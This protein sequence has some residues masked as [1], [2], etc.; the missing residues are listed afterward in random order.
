MN[1]LSLLNNPTNN[2][3]G[4]ATPSGSYLSETLRALQ[5]ERRDY[6]ED[7]RSWSS[8]LRRP[9]SDVELRQI[10][11]DALA[12]VYDAQGALLPIGVGHGK[13]LI[14]FLAGAILPDVRYTLF[15]TPAP[16]V[17]ARARDWDEWSA[18]FALPTCRI[19]SYWELSHRPA[20]LQGILAGIGPRHLLVVADEAH[21]LGDPKA[22]RTKRI[23]RTARDFPAIRWLFMSGTLT[24]KSLRQFAHLSAIALRDKSPLPRPAKDP[25][26]RSIDL[27]AWSECVDDGGKPDGTSWSKIRHLLEQYDLAA[28][29]TRGQ[30][31]TQRARKAF[32]L[33]LGGSIGVVAS[34]KSALGC[35]LLIEQVAAPLS[36]EVTEALGMVLAGE[37]PDGE[38]LVDDVSSWRAGRQV[39][40]GFY[41]RWDWRAINR[42]TPDQ[43]WLRARQRWFQHVRRELDIASAPDYDSPALVEAETRRRIDAWEERRRPLIQHALISWDQERHKP[44]PPTVPV[45]IDR[46]ILAWVVEGLGERRPLIWYE[47]TAVAD[48]L[49][50]L[51]LE[52]IRAGQEVV[53]ERRP[54]CVSIP[55]HREGLNLQAWDDNIILECPS[56]GKA[57]E[58]L[59]GRTHRPGQLSDEVKASVLIQGALGASLEKARRSARYIE[60][61][62]GQTQKLN[63][64]TY[65][66]A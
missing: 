51:G 36:D 47:S 29:S 43:Q 64:A 38:V 35:S 26:H 65:T 2:P 14:G 11:A 17:Q 10:Q 8:F 32:Q 25:K 45:W 50:R 59:L 12:A 57:G 3:G 48:E 21:R 58:Q 44:V 18:H 19:V 28:V 49:E 20:T 63:F 1:L 34:K 23:V 22:S 4:A 60:D 55:A 5:V 31:R 56:G 53:G 9:G 42:E 7:P 15:I 52:V 39:S 46:S 33:H 27:D 6:A 62:T 24:S 61:T 41:Y 16:T 66:E 37:R 13:T 40:L 54:L 30:E